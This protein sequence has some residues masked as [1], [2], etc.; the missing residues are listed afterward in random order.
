MK[1]MIVQALLFA[2][3]LLSGILAFSEES[4]VP[5]LNKADRYVSCDS[6]SGGCFYWV[7][8]TSGKV[9]LA[10]AVKEGIVWKFMG[11]V[12]DANLGENG[13]Y[14]PYASETSRGLFILNT[15]TGEGW[16]TNWKDWKNLGKPSDVGQ[17][18]KTDSIA[19]GQQSDLNI[20]PFTCVVQAEMEV[21]YE[22]HLDGK[23]VSSSKTFPPGKGLMQAIELTATPGD[24]ILMVTAQ[25]C[26]TWQKTVTIVGRTSNSKSGLSFRID[27]KKS[28]K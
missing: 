15:A 7:D 18:E 9:W 8:T 12:K 13:T 17:S 14:I 2:T 23:F 20:V 1:R 25:G 6:Y 21:L 16:W 24:H 4:K 19:T 28:D 11:Q 3:V 10:V 26:E 5:E 27:L 22:I